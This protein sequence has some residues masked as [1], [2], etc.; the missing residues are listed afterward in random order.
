MA[1]RGPRSPERE[2]SH[3]RCEGVSTWIARGSAA[4][5]TRSA[6]GVGGRHNVRRRSVQLEW[7][8]TRSAQAE[9]GGAVAE[10]S[11]AV[12]RRRGVEAR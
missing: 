1:E 8:N 5:A 10:P 11:A 4:R 12:A 6:A 7:N 9:V 3:S 2:Q